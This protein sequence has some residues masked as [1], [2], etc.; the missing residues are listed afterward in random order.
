MTS[1]SPADEGQAMAR[2]FPLLGATTL[3]A[4]AC[5]V[6]PTSPAVADEPRAQ[7]VPSAIASP[8][9]DPGT[10]CATAEEFV[11][12]GDQ[13]RAEEVFSAVPP[14]V[15]GV[16]AAAG[17][18][19]VHEHRL[20][21]DHWVAEGQRALRAGHLGS[22]ET[23]FN[24]ALSADGGNKDAVAGLDRLVAL[25]GH[26]L[27]TASSNWDYFYDD[28]VQPIWKLLLPI[29][30]GFAVLLAAASVSSRWLVKAKSVAWTDRRRRSLSWIG[31]LL[32]FHGA[33]MLPVYPMFMPYVPH[34]CLLL[35]ALVLAFAIVVATA[36]LVWS[37]AV[38]I[39]G[40]AGWAV[41]H[42]KSRRVLKDWRLLLISLLVVL[43]LGLLLAWT[44]LSTAYERL[45]VAYT[46]LLLFGV[47]L[48]GA[49]W[50]QRLRLQVEVH[51]PDGS[52][53]AAST[54]YLLTRMQS[55]G[56]ERRT[57]VIQFSDTTPL[58][59]LSGDQLSALPTGKVLGALA[60]LYFALRPD[61]TWRARANLVD[62][63]RVAVTILRNGQPAGSAIFS[64]QDLGLPLAGGS[65]E[66]VEVQAALA[67]SRAQ[68]LTGAAAFV[69]VELRQC[70]LD[71][72]HSLYGARDW[73]SVA[74][75]VIATSKS[76]IDAPDLAV[77]LLGQ[78]TDLDPH[79]VLAR[80][81]FL[82]AV[83]NRI[84]AAEQDHLA[85]A[86]AL[87][88][89]TEYVK[90]DI[91]D[92]DQWPGLL[93]RIHYSS[94]THRL[95]GYL[96][97][98]RTAEH[99]LRR[100]KAVATAL[101]D[102]CGQESDVRYL[103]QLRDRMRP[104][105][106]NLLHCIEVLESDPLTEFD[107]WQHPHRRDPLS[108]RLAFDHA[109]LDCFLLMTTRRQDWAG[110]AVEDLRFALISEKARAAAQEDPCLA[111]LRTD[112]GFRNLVGLPPTEFLDL[113]ALSTVRQRLAD[114]GIT[115]SQ[116]LRAETDTPDARAC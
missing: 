58:S 80:F 105:A 63:N 64:R 48:T 114:A 26:A 65:S 93:L 1:D 6:L 95:Y 53:D 34:G 84:P 72:R 60:Q 5:C 11:D 35:A 96:A 83:N 68:L 77:S 23:D 32:L 75:Q 78:A 44:G 29:A 102:Q 55:L 99:A 86:A 115:S 87:D 79:Y 28:W 62:D 15:T 46:V 38:D 57:S 3:L 56:I 43:G 25:R 90:Q 91:E 70:H 101:Y 14:V 7:P 113:A 59:S 85:F 76:L 2:R 21:A 30:I 49:A 27:P 41:W 107:T 100:A 13:D 9:P 10:M 24:A 116:R 88:E 22:A 66:T 42:P 12:D 69:L 111:P 20:L 89:Y 51:R 92:L 47:L 73:R 97:S 108:P 17:L 98:G 110:K 109:C 16:C 50:G 112:P 71:L 4:L 54:N 37:A 61:L 74:L 52:T 104:F 81:E 94:A 33:V 31:G 39:A 40:C 8:S 67:R 82:W 18:R 45:L 106:Q 103:Q 36:A 19:Q